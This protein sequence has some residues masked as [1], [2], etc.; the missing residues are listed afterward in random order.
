M[1]AIEWANKMPAE[2]SRETENGQWEPIHAP[3]SGALTYRIVHNNGPAT[4]L[5]ICPIPNREPLLL[6][7]ER[8]EWLQRQIV[9]PK[10]LFYGHQQQYEFLHCTE[11][12]G[13]NA[14]DRHRFSSDV[15][16][17]IAIFAEGLRTFHHLPVRNCPFD[18][19]LKTRLNIA[20]RNLED[21]TLDLDGIKRLFPNQSPETFYEELIT[22]QQ[23][24]EDDLVVNHGDYSMPN[25]VVY[26]GGVGGFIDVGN[27][28]IADKYFDLA[29]AVKSIVRNYGEKWVP[30]FY[31]CPSRWH[32]QN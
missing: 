15:R 30:I 22:R 32:V 29:V 5:K 10:L 25:L 27:C 7:K 20:K 9:V 2:L 19:T 14:S 24:M 6:A 8:L 31:K 1:K 21:G 18:H 3:Y 12:E 28:G 4:Y 13:D 16:G 26:K 11:I 23:Q 17:L